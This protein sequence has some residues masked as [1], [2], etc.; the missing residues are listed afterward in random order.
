MEVL[1]ERLSKKQQ[2]IGLAVKKVRKVEDPSTSVPPS[3]APSWAV[4]G[5]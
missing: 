4:I 5:M 1:D 2:P 3:D